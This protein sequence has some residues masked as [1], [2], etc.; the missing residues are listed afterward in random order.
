MKLSFL[1]RLKTDQELRQRFS[2]DPAGTLR[3]CGVDPTPFRLPDRVS[4][5]EVDALVKF[6]ARSLESSDSAIDSS[7]KVVGVPVY[8]PPPGGRLNPP[9]ESSPLAPS[10]S[11]LILTWVAAI[12][13]ALGLLLAAAKVWWALF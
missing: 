13:L 10:G 6:L 2:L 7:D 1:A 8:G 11:R 12:A 4:P 3:E 5:S 9:S